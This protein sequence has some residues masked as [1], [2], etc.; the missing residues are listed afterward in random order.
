MKKLLFVS[1]L[2]SPFM[3]AESQDGANAGGGGMVGKPDNS[4]I[5]VPDGTC[6][7][8]AIEGVDLEKCTLSPSS[9]QSG[10]QSW[11]CPPELDSETGETV[12]ICAT[13]NENE[14]DDGD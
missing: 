13:V 2:I 14:D 6:V 10:L 7:T 9:P 11:I 4:F 3:A 1:L 5:T 8:L 12:V